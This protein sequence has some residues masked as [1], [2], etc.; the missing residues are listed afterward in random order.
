M[1]KMLTL[2]I[3]IYMYFQSH[4]IQIKREMSCLGANLAFI[5][6]SS[7]AHSALGRNILQ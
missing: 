6:C 7:Q 2:F 1:L 3:S 4:F 5:T